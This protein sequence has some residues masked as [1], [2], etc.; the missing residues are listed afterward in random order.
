MRNG[1]SGK[2]KKASSVALWR[3]F[4]LQECIEPAVCVC[5][6]DA[7]CITALLHTQ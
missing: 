2:E 3:H 5:V 4:K 7:T 6:C 1:M